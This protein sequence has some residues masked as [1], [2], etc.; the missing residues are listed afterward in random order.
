MAP[1]NSKR[2][3][4]SGLCRFRSGGV[5]LYVLF[6]PLVALLLMILTVQP[7]S[8]Q[9][10]TTTLIS[11]PDGTYTIEVSMEGGT[12]RASITSP[13]VL[14][15]K[16]SVATVQIEW[17]SSHYD[18]MIVD[19]EKYL[20]INEDGNSVFEIPLPGLDTEVTIIADTTAMSTP[21]EIEYTLVF[22]SNSI[23]SENAFPLIWPIVRVGLAALL[24]CAVVI[25][26][27]RKKRKEARR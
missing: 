2:P 11:L 14:T 18:Y 22:D 24:L 15:I 9:A 5:L 12:G 27:V 23:S 8:L 20:P 10:E 13:A 19:N 3:S 4:L 26:I 6:V 21:H 7:L 16:E 17:S 25:V 1:Q